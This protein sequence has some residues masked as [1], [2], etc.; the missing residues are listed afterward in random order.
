VIS[1][2]FG[3]G[4]KGGVEAVECR[5]CGVTM[6]RQAWLGSE[7]FDPA[8]VVAAFKQLFSV[9]ILLRSR[10]AGCGN[11]YSRRPPNSGFGVDGRCQFYLIYPPPRWR[12]R[13]SDFPLGFTYRR[14]LLVLNW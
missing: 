11:W 8:A 9:I 12:A 7:K 5:R 10:P 14:P 4:T 2:K 3:F 13:D 1:K 6:T